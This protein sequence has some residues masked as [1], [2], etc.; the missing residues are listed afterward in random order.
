MKLSE[1]LQKLSYGQLSELAIAGEGTGKVPDE[2]V[3]KLIVRINDALTALYTRFDLQKRSVILETADGVYAYQLAPQFAQ[4]SGSSEIYKY[5]KDTV[6]NPFL[7]DLLQITDVLGNQGALP[8]DPNYI[9]VPR[10]EDN[11]WISLPLNDRNDRLS[12]HT[13]SYDT[14]AM[15]YP[16]TGDR[17]FIQYRAK[18]VPIP[19]QPTE[20]NKIEIRVP[21]ALETALLSH[22]AGNVFAGMSMESALGKSQM[23]LKTYEAECSL[24]ELRDTFAQ[25]NEGSNAKPAMGG[26]V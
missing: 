23:L 6:A 11:D 26:W 8:T 7:D 19:L 17:Y 12:W 4:L 1:L 13:L 9:T 14:L 20:L 5:I 24:H 10:L 25:F 18:H 3:P 22:V 21:A 2:N 16:K 15:D